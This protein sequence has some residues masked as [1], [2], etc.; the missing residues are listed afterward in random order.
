MARISGAWMV[1]VS[2]GLALSVA[3]C[4]RET[5]A[6]QT[7]EQSSRDIHALTAGAVGHVT[8]EQA[9]KTYDKVAKDGKDAAA[10][11]KTA[12][13]TANTILAS[14]ATLG[15]SD[16]PADRFID[17]EAESGRR[18]ASI[19]DLLTDWI[20]RS[21]TERASQFDPKPELKAIDAREA[22]LKKALEQAKATLATREKAKAELVAQAQAKADQ[23][24]KLD[25][26]SIALKLQADKTSDTEA[27]ALIEKSAAQK[28]EADAQHKTA[29]LIGL[30]AD[31][32]QPELDE[33][34]L[35]VGK[36]TNQITSCEHARADVN[37]RAEV[38]A[39]QVATSR[40]GASKAANTL[41][42]ELDELRKLRSG[43][44]A[45]SF[46]DATSKLDAARKMAKQ[47]GAD[48]AAQLAAARG[49]Q[50]LGELQRT[51]GVGILAYADLLSSL[52][53]AKPALPG[54]A[55]Y[56][57]E[58]K[59]VT[60]EGK[61]A[62]EE[63][64]AAFTDASEGFGKVRAPG[65]ADLKERLEEVSKRLAVIAERAAEAPGTAS[66]TPAAGGISAGEIPGDAP[67]DL[68]AAVAAYVG[69]LNGGDAETQAAMT[70]AD[71]EQGK[72][73]IESMKGIG[74]K[75]SAL[76]K[77][78][79][80]K[81]GQK[82]SELA[83]KQSGGMGGGMF[84]GSS[85]DP[86]K[87]TVSVEGEHGKVSGAG[88]PQAMN[89]SKIKGKWVVDISEEAKSPMMA[90]ASK[91]MD[92]I[93][94][95]MGEF[96]SNVEAGKYDSADAAMKAFMSQMQALMMKAM[97]GGAPGGDKAEPAPTK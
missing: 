74:L 60:E 26:Q 44:L 33:L 18:I 53:S 37:K 68:K 64:K 96:T 49:A 87:L 48:S 97:T 52:A 55:K 93:K 29:K 54:Q 34:A 15:Q 47:A 80:A 3:S 59:N 86:A 20:A 78:F 31:Q 24:K 25:E 32:I 23:A 11:D 63:S 66:A 65:K 21:A 51:R 28:R 70:Y 67:D 82:F 90:M 7:V 83:G 91:M 95:A 35:E 39:G 61:K 62:L 36:L 30:Q 58:A 76:D 85:V 79:Q 84:A 8:N 57:E 14:Q 56:L 50:G 69:A 43:E 4:N 1:V 89:F 81:Y 46:S 72:S 27:L 92:P 38:A 71:S 42:K 73:L 41:D 13:G 9:K 6:Q 19:R 77:I 16:I 12:V 2:A 5:P 22:E 45:Q 75:V 94:D 10:N 17:L 40:E 88:L